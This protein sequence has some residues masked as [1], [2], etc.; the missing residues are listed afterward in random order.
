MALYHRCS[1]YLRNHI[2]HELR[3]Q[4]SFSTVAKDAGV[5][6]NTVIRYFDYIQ[7]PKPGHLPEVL[8]IDE[9]KGN[10]D[11]EKFQCILVDVAKSYFPNAVITTDKYCFIR[12]E[13]WAIEGLR[14]RLQ[15]TIPTDLRKYY[16]HSRS[17]ILSREYKIV[18]DKRRELDVMLTYNDN[19]RHAHW[20][21][22]EILNAFKYG[23]TNGPTEG[24]NNKI[25]VLKHI[26]YGM[27]NF[28]RFRNHILH[29]D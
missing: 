16:K 12:Q 22:Y 4:T 24:F 1:K 28:E 27:Q 21:K 20:L 5:S 19:L 8:C 9:F 10:T 15:K 14:K 29:C 3:K 2:L 7:Y 25:K 17:L 6:I 13:T 23:Y 18:G 26:S 11:K